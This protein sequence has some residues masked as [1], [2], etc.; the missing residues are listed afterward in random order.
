MQTATDTT[1]IASLPPL[2]PR[3]ILFGNPERARPQLSPDGKFLAY[4]A[5][6]EK[7][8]LQV[9]LRPVDSEPS[10]EPA[11][12]KQITADKKRGIRAYFWTYDGNHLIYMQDA[13]GD[14]N[15]HCYSVDIHTNIVRDLTPFQGVKAEPIELD[16]DFSDQ[17]LVGMNLN[18]PQVFDV[19]RLNLHT[20]AVEFDTQNP[21]NIINWLSDPQFQIR[22]AVA[23]TP[24]GGSDLLYRA[25][26]DQPWEV[27]RHWSADDEGYPVGFAADGN[28]LYIV[29]N[30]EAN[31]QRLLALDLTTRQET[32]IAEDPQYDV[33]GVITHPTDRQLQAVA[34]YREKLNWQILDE[35]IAADFEALSALR[36]GEFSIGSRTLADDR[37]LVAYTTDDGPVYYYAYDRNTKTSTLLFSNQPALEQITLAPMQ[38]ISYPARD[39]LTIQGYLTTP[40]GITAENLPAVL[41]VH[42]GPWARDTWGYDPEAQWLANRG[43]AVLQVN[44]RGS[45]GYG[46]AFLNAGNREWA[47]KMHDDLLDG[48]EWLVAQ[49][50]ADRSKIA[51]MGGSYGGY[52][53]LVGLTFTPEVFAAGV[54]IVGPS[55]IMTLLQSIP[56]YWEPIKAQMYHRIG[57]METEAEFLKSRSPLFFIDQIQKPLLIGQGANDPRV[58]QAE[59]DQIVEAMRQAGKPVEYALYPDEGHGFARPENRLHFYATAEAFLTKYLGGR[60]EP[61]GEIP[62][63]SG[64]LK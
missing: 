42:G 45:T 56:P 15:F 26:V 44:F 28:T 1:T 9:W 39:G 43:Y 18:D 52:A 38:P 49:G 30:H 19:Y 12:A 50:I 27:L 58:K 16:P 57:N 53:T 31:A 41:L 62:G 14:E 22:V 47:A 6:D 3:E 33:G 2:I 10:G 23:A 51:I 63:H 55:N 59:S 13:D 60:C 36:P 32:V 34:F 48:V 29:G 37:W 11:E 25:T 40:A 17:F 24:D 4:I 61:I 54:D 64:V 8:V 20:G 5:P 46:K 35:R 7:N 21:G